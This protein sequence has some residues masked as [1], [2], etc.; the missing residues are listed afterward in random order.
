MKLTIFDDW[1]VG[2]VSSDEKSVRD[3]TAL[4]PAAFDSWGEQRMNWL[5]R[6]WEAVKEEAS[7]EA[8]AVW[9]PLDSV[10]VRAVNPA[11]DRSLDCLLI[12]MPT[13]VKL[14]T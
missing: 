4:V 3:I 7:N 11:P 5:I 2:A 9:L 8:D 12:S 10:L 14:A 6:N 1:R 13:W